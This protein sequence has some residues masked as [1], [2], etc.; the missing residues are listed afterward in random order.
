MNPSLLTPE[1]EPR[2]GTPSRQVTGISLVIPVFNEEG[3]IAETLRLVRDALRQASVAY[4]IIVVNDGST[5][6][7]LDAIHDA[8]AGPDVRLIEHRRNRGYGAALKSGIRYARYAWIA[9]VDADGSYPLEELTGLVQLAGDVDMVV[10]SRTGADANPPGLRGLTRT[11]LRGFAQWLVHR[12]IPDL[13]SGLRV[14]RK[15]LAERFLRILPDGFSFTSTIT[16]ALLTNGYRVHFEPIHYYRRIGRSKIRPVRDTLNVVRL[17]ARTAIYFAPFR[18]FLP[19]AALFLVGFLVT[20]GWE[21][22]TQHEFDQRSWLA[23]AASAHFGLCALLANRI[24]RGH[25]PDGKQ[26]PT[27]LPGRESNSRY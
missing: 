23:L 25:R 13:N 14:F 7:T 22:W 5:D 9:I 2:P 8:F 21:A 19:M 12:R 6:R 15:D 18:V 27:T 1:S 3:A 4:E 11:V 26:R 16:L 24:G 10:G 20:C 17:I